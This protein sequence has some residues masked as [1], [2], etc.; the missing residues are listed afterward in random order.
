MWGN[1]EGE[2]EKLQKDVDE[3]HKTSVLKNMSKEISS[4]HQDYIKYMML[5]SAYHSMVI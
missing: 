1:N 4:S 3:S 5:V 2:A